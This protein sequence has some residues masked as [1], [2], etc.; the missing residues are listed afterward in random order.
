MRLSVGALTSLAIV[1]SVVVA[2]GAAPQAAAV[3]QSE[4]RVSKLERCPS[5]FEDP[6]GQRVMVIIFNKDL[7]VETFYCPGSGAKPE[8]AHG[9]GKPVEIVDIVPQLLLRT[10]L[11]DEPDPCYE[12]QSGGES[13]SVCW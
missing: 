12:W 9:P 8:A 11:P 13:R 6:A 2:L 7:T 1:A 10:R 4:I 5:A 3:D